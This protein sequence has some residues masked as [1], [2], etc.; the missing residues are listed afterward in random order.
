[1]LRAALD[2]YSDM[3]LH[4]EDGIVVKA[5]AFTMISTCDILRHMFQEFGRDGIKDVPIPSFDGATIRVAVDVIHGIT[6]VTELSFDEVEK[7]CKGFEY[8]G[9]TILKKKI[10]ARIWHFVSKAEDTAT[11]LRCVDKLLVSPLHA[12]D[13]LNKFKSLAPVW[14]DFKTIFEHVTMTEDIA[15]VCMWRLSRFFPAHLIF[16]VLIDAFPPN[17]LSFDTCL[18]VMGCYRTGKYHHPDE[19]V[20]SSNKILS[21]FKDEDRAIHLQA[22]SDAFCEYDVSPSGSKLIGTTLTFANEPKT[23]VLAKIY[24]PFRG[25]KVLRI[26]RTMT[27]SVNTV[28]GLVGGTCDVE[29]LDENQCYPSTILVRIMTYNTTVLTGRDTIDHGYD[30]TETWREFDN[31]HY[32]EILQLDHPNSKNDAAETI[33]SNAVKSPSLRYVRLDFFYGHGDI[34]HL[35]IF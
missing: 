10:L 24:D 5:N 4:C 19:L 2:T 28:N 16:D 8:L 23:S 25:T 26:K 6:S 14:N 22:I 12:R 18:K 31:V 17:H 33:L 11:V 29:K 15:L 27:V 1:M 3:N 35:P 21:K 30:T 7:C 20:M 13:T 32:G 9:C 34:R